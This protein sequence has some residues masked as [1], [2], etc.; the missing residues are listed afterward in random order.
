MVHNVNTACLKTLRHY[1]YLHT[2][3]SILLTILCIPV[4]L[5][6]QTSLIPPPTSQFLQGTKTDDLRITVENSGAIQI[7]QMS[8]SGSFVHQLVQ[9]PFA[10]GSYLTSS[11][12]TCGLGFNSSTN[13]VPLSNT[14]VG[15]DTIITIIECRDRNGTPWAIWQQRIHYVSGDYAFIE[16]TISNPSGTAISDVRFFH[17][18]TNNLDGISPS[19]SGFSQDSLNKIGARIINGTGALARAISFQAFTLP[20]ARSSR[21]SS[22]ISADILSGAS[23]VLSNIIDINTHSN[24]AFALQWLKPNDLQPAEQWVLAGQEHILTAPISNF[25]YIIPPPELPVEPGV[26][27]TYP[28]LLVNADPSNSKLVSLNASTTQPG[29]TVSSTNSVNLSPNSQTDVLVNLTA[30]GTS[31][32]GSF[33]T[34]NLQATI[35]GLTVSGKTNAIVNFNPNLAPTSTPT[36]IPKAVEVSISFP[37]SSTGSATPSI[38][39]SAFP[40]STVSLFVDDILVGS[41]IADSSGL[42]SLNITPPLSIG[43]HKLTASSID[44][45][46]RLSIIASPFNLLYTGGA[47]LDFE[48]D[49]FSDFNTYVNLGSSVIYR[50]RQSSND[51]SKIYSV[52]GVVPAPADYDGDGT[53]DF[54]AI[55]RSGKSFIWSASLSSSNNQEIENTLGARGDT[56]ISGCYFEAGHK[57][58]MAALRGNDLYFSSITNTETIKIDNILS[59]SISLLGC[60]DIDGDKI[61]ELIATSGDRIQSI[62]AVNLKKER[63]QLGT[64][65]K[66]TRGYVM[67]TPNN[68][69][70][71]LLLVRVESATQRSLQPF[72]LTSKESF[73]KIKIP[74]KLIVGSG[75]VIGRDGKT[76]EKGIFYQDLKTSKVLG[77]LLNDINQV[78]DLTQISRGS[79]VVISQYLYPTR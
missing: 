37:F 69:Q 50:L 6:A 29:W 62:F 60:A 52:K 49:G 51:S 19:S 35:N 30:P 74:R 12:G 25:V 14:I 22:L 26:S 8:T 70:P 66:F 41:T 75:L 24:N 15:Q 73:D 58:S 44:A 5:F 54:A 9:S 3:G 17:V 38:P 57:S 55:R 23:P 40:G 11:A 39:G 72:S 21:S 47:E 77:F 53:I 2:C 18:Q 1:I 71:L 78:T 10:N 67:R 46:S 64:T 68:S 76:L 65:S 28:A 63:I 43:S 33:A 61:D 59:S 32:L 48:G 34:I 56:L 27:N 79:R 31:T 4:A 36:S 7:E 13:A 20:F 45:F 42:W 16:W